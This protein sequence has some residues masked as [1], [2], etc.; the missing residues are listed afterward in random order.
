[1]K[2]IE[3]NIQ[4]ELE[5][6]ESFGIEL[7]KLDDEPTPLAS[8]KT[9]LEKLHINANESIDTI[10]M[11]S[12]NIQDSIR[13]INKFHNQDDFKIEI[14]GHKETID[15]S[16]RNKRIKQ[17]P[18]ECI[19]TQHVNLIKLKETHHISTTTTGAVSVEE[20]TDYLLFLEPYHDGKKFGEF[21]EN[22]KNNI[23]LSEKDAQELEFLKAR[24]FIPTPQKIEE[25][26]QEFSQ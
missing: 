10:Y 26:Q 5:Y 20:E 23:V 2:K 22:K 7:T 14:L 8:I 12:Y 9:E 6:L 13:Y 15:S 19:Y 24:M 16:L 1:M 25:L 11:M 21:Y 17:I 18:S 3:L 4:E